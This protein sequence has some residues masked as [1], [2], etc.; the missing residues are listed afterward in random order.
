VVAVI[1]IAAVFLLRKRPRAAFAA[2]IA[3]GVFA[4]PVFNLTNVSLLL[5]A[6][7]A[8]DRELLAEQPSSGSM[9]PVPAP[10]T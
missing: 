9:S 6:F 10:A 7:V 2:A 8:V 4:S 1:G 3:T 5:A